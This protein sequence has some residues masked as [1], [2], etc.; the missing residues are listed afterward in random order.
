MPS[1]IGS[2]IQFSKVPI[3]WFVWV[4]V[5]NQSTDVVKLS[6]LS[7][8]ETKVG[9]LPGVVGMVAH[10]WTQLQSLHSLHSNLHPQTQS[11]DTPS[12]VTY[13]S[14]VY[15]VTSMFLYV[16]CLQGNLY[17]FYMWPV[18][19]VTSMFLYVSCLQGNLYVFICGLFTR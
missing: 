9:D 18:Y 7:T 2:V 12:S 10:P 17:V 6:S 5:P 14:P 16:A 4:R 1:I 8:C 13:M 3:L 19:K 15:K 11:P